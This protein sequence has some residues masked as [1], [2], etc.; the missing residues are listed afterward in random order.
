MTI[1]DNLKKTEVDTLVRFHNEHPE[2]SIKRK[3]KEVKDGIRRDEAPSGHPG[4]CPVW[5]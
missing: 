2:R 5:R 3:C 4:V 1:W